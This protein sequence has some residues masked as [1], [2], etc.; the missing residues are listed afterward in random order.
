MIVAAIVITKVS[1][2]KSRL[3]TSKAAEKLRIPV[4]RAASRRIV[5]IA[6]AAIT[7]PI[8]IAPI[9]SNAAPTKM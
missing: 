5:G 4:P 9:P 3:A 7:Q 1:P 8:A 6:V 2:P